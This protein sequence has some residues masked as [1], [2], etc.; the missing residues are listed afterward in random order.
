M[1]Q[2]LIERCIEAFNSAHKG[3]D[4]KGAENDAPVLKDY[5]AVLRGR[6]LTLSGRAIDHPLLGSQLIDTSL[7]IHVTSDEKW[8]RTLSRWYRLEESRKVDT[9]RAFPG[10]DIAGYCLP[11]GADAVTIPMHLARKVMSQRPGYLSKIALEAGFSKEA[12][13][14]DLIDKKWPPN[15]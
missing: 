3:P 7:L 1:Y 9:S 12:E 8:A 10:I 14:L 5:T 6:N 2:K 4:P 11:L 15:C 13:Q